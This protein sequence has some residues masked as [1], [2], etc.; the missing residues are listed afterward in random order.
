MAKMKLAHLV[1]V[2]IAG[3][4]AAQNSDIGV[5]FSTVVTRYD[6]GSRTETQIRVGVQGNFALQLFEGRS[7]R[8]YV[9][10]PVSAFAGPVGQGVITDLG[11]FREISR[12]EGVFFVTPGIRYH[13]Y[14]TPRVAFYAAAGVGA[15]V[16]KKKTFHLSNSIESS[17]NPLLSTSTGWKISPAFDLGAGLDFR[18]T[19]LLSFRGEVRTFR[20][21]RQPGFGDGR[22]YPSA[23]LGLAFHY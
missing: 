8:L 17:S 10:A 1:F 21:S 15:A 7:G 5:L 19:R 14:L 4:A 12:P 6:L 3:P 2:L 20:T 22:Q 23:H 9:E 16:R 18:I 13:Y 11:D